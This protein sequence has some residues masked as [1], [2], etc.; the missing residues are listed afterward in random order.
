MWNFNQD[1]QFKHSNLLILTFQNLENFGML[2]TTTLKRNLVPE[3]RE[4]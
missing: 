4:G 3:I 2:Q 1:K